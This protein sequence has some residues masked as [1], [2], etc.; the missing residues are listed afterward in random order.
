LEKHRKAQRK[1]REH[2]GNL[3]QDGGWIFTNLRGGP[4]HP[5]VDHDAWKALLKTAKVRDARLHDARH[6]AA[7]MLLLLGVPT[8]AVMDVMP[9][10][11]QVVDL[12]RWCW[13]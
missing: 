6:T 12:E 1:E 11:Y 8:R 13:C 9:D 5:R 7:T 2:A 10:S 3:W 4:V